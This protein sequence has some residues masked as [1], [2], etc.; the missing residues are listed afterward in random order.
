M[1]VKDYVVFGTVVMIAGFV[2]GFTGIEN[3]ADFKF[4]LGR[5]KGGILENL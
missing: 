5:D 2:G 4:P 1:D 3:P